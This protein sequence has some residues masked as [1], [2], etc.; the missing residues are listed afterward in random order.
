[1]DVER[2]VLATFAS[3]PGGPLE[4]HCQFCFSLSHTLGVV[5][6]P[7]HVGL[8]DSCFGWTRPDN[9]VYFFHGLD[10][11]PA[12]VKIGKSMW[13]PEFMT[14]SETLCMN[15]YPIAAIN[16][17]WIVLAPKDSSKLMMW[18]VGD[19]GLAQSFMAVDCSSMGC[20]LSLRFFGPI[21]QYD[22]DSE[23]L[24]VFF[25]HREQ[26]AWFLSVFHL[27]MNTTWKEREV[28]PELIAQCNLSAV[29]L[30]AYNLYPPLVDRAE[31]KY[32]L[33]FATEIGNYTDKQ[34]QKLLD[35]NTA[36]T[37]KWFE[38]ITGEVE[39]KAVD[40]SHI[41]ITTSDH[42]S[43]SVF[44]LSSL[45]HMNTF[46]QQHKAVPC[47]THQHP[48]GTKSVAAGCGV[49]VTS[50]LSTAPALVASM[51][52]NT[53]TPF[54]SQ[55]IFGSPFNSATTTVTTTHTFVDALTGTTL[56]TMT[57]NN[58]IF[59]QSITQIHKYLFASSTAKYL[60]EIT[61]LLWKTSSNTK[62]MRRIEDVGLQLLPGALTAASQF[63][64]LAWPSFLTPR[65]IMGR[66]RPPP[67]ARRG[68]CHVSALPPSVLVECIGKRWVT[69]VDRPVLANFGLGART[70]YEVFFS[71]SHTLGLVQA[72]CRVELY[73]NVL[74]WIAPD[75]CV[76]LSGDTPDYQHHKVI[77]G[78]LSEGEDGADRPKVLAEWRDDDS[79][80]ARAACGTRWIAISPKRSEKLLVWKVQDGVASDD[81]T[82]CR[83]A[84][85][86][87]Q[88]RFWCTTSEY[89]SESDTLELI[90]LEEGNCIV[91]QHVD[92][93]EVWKEG[94]ITSPTI[95]A[96]CDLSAELSAGLCAPLVDRAKGSYYLPVTTVH[97]QRK[98]VKRFLTTQKTLEYLSFKKAAS[99]SYNQM[100][101]GISTGNHLAWLKN[102]TEPLEVKAVDEA[103]LA[104]TTSDHSSTSVFALSSLCEAAQLRRC[105]HPRPTPLCTYRHPPGTQAVTSGCGLLVTSTTVQSALPQPQWD[106][107]L[108]DDPECEV[109]HI[110]HHPSS[111]RRLGL[112]YNTAAP[113][114]MHTFTDAV[115]GDNPHCGTV[116]CLPPDVIRAICLL[117]K[118]ECI[119]FMENE[120]FQVTDSGMTATRTRGRDIDAYLWILSSDSFCL[121]EYS[122]VDLSRVKEINKTLRWT[123]GW[124]ATEELVTKTFDLNQKAQWKKTNATSRCYKTMFRN[125]GTMVGIIG[126][127]TKVDVS[128]FTFS[129]YQ[130]LCKPPGCVFS[131]MLTCHTGSVFWSEPDIFYFNTPPPENCPAGMLMQRKGTEFT[132]EVDLNS[133]TVEMFAGDVSL[134]QPITLPRVT[135][136]GQCVY[137]YHACALHSFDTT[138]KLIPVSN[139]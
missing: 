135:A 120:T 12:S 97:K 139:H 81:H 85:E 83:V 73:V 129:G 53:Y 43:T 134:C 29:G 131:V 101:I 80:T 112:P 15:P 8:W 22:C 100:L 36:F 115:S 30:C 71:L 70:G 113:L 84:K 136:D 104:T 9:V 91:V 138:V 64:A 48:T 92:L 56:F 31:R 67:A 41:S 25:Y 133:G 42:S 76:L 96:E 117:L 38:N 57:L 124:G 17:R 89:D 95:V 40:E 99:T 72:P 52:K 122:G 132:V 6:G 1:M 78:Q 107:A 16:R 108:N 54:T 123:C 114:S 116:R 105:V 111:S 14:L 24:E 39:V 28:D 119:E 126:F 55:K 35:L 18:R 10:K 59:P 79:R 63:V 46:A 50:S 74:G 44:S 37:I 34:A 68:A 118:P 125:G 5:N 82:E 65:K 60:L 45:I 90:F 32:Y 87:L 51:L 110:R 127:T 62:K 66:R 47:I 19:D 77:V 11:E 102:V 23:I 2:V 69:A 4:K 7:W 94:D 49:I 137:W 130:H 33:P 13:G 27:D 75:R 109:L 20:L 61:T 26:G 103:H 98:K 106:A 21:N 88:L 3:D 93:N 121:P 86:L 128:T 58:G